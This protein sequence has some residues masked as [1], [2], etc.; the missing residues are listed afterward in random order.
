MQTSRAA[1]V[2]TQSSKG[3]YQTAQTVILHG[4]GQRNMNGLIGLPSL[5]RAE[6]VDQNGQDRMRTGGF[7]QAIDRGAG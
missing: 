2:S 6:S 5:H 1:P 4:T 3:G 7:N